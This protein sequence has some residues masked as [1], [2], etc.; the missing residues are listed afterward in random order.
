VRKLWPP[1][2]DDFSIRFWAAAA[3]GTINFAIAILLYFRLALFIILW[4]MAPAILTFMFVSRQDFEGASF[5]WSGLIAGIAANFVFYYLVAWLF[6]R[7]FR[8]ATN[9]W[10]EKR[11]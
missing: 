4:T 9:W 6:I 8:P 1:T 3:S 2:Y 10:P 11:A 5:S 7:A